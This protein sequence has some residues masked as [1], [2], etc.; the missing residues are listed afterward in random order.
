M[1]WNLSLQ[2]L[3]DGEAVDQ[4]VEDLWAQSPWHE[5]ASEAVLEQR[6]TAKAALKALIDSGTVGNGPFNA[7]LYG[8]AHDPNGESSAPNAIGVSV[9]AILS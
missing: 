7:S 2:D 6:D 3:A 5:G 8:H 9:S 1:S 4:K